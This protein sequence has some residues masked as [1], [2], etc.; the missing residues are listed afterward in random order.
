MISAVDLLN[1]IGVYA[2]MEILTVEGATGYTDTNYRGK[3]E[4]HFPP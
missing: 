4:R 2:G 3:A 1:G